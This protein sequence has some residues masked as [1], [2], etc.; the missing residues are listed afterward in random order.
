[1][2]CEPRKRVKVYQFSL[3]RRFLCSSP[4]VADTVVN[5]IRTEISIFLPENRL[6][7]LLL[8]EISQA[9]KII[10]V[11]VCLVVLGVLLILERFVVA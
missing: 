5:I 3:H 1:M 4:R 9:S 2:R 8:T 7:P 11:V 10:V 6:K